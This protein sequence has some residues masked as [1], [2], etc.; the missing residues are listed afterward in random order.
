MAYTGF[1]TQVNGASDLSP[2]LRQFGFLN[3]G[4]TL[5]S[6]GLNSDGSNWRIA[7]GNAIAAGA[8][9]RGFSA[10]GQP[11]YNT[12]TGTRLPLTGMGGAANGWGTPPPPPR[13]GPGGPTITPVIP[14]PPGVIGAGGTGRTPT[15]PPAGAAPPPSS[16]PRPGVAPIGSPSAPPVVSSPAINQNTDT[17]NGQGNQ[18]QTPDYGRLF[19]PT[20]YDGNPVDST[21]Q[22]MAVQPPD[23]AGPGAPGQVDFNRLFNP[24]GYDGTTVGYDAADYL[25]GSMAGSPTISGVMPYSG[26]TGPNMAGGGLNPGT[27]PSGPNTMF[28]T[29][30]GTSSADPST[31]P[32]GFPTGA[33]TLGQSMYPWLTGY[34]GNFTAPMT[35]Y[36][37]QGLNAISQ[38]VGGG[39]NLGGAQSYLSNLLSGQYLDPS[40]NP[41]LAKYVSSLSGIHDYQDE[42]EKER[43]GS[44]MAAGGNALSGARAM[45]ESQYQ[46]ESNN[47]YQNMIASMLNSDYQMERGLQN[48]AVPLQMGISN[49]LMG[50]YGNLMNAG[51]L[52]RSIQQQENNAEYQDWLRQISGMQQAFQAPENSML[53]LL[54]SGYPGSQQ[55][56]YQGSAADSWLAALLGNGSG[57]SGL[58]NA[59]FG[60]GT[61]GG[62]SGGSSGGLLGSLANLLGIGGGSSS[63]GNTGGV[64]DPNNP[65]GDNYGGGVPTG[66]NYGP[67]PD[68]QGF[69][70][71]AGDP[72]LDPSNYATDPWGALD[73][74]YQ[75]Q[76]QQGNV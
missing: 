19:N 8:L 50:G 32:G 59:L 75:E 37:N 17:G 22:Q 74:W 57:S 49:E 48:Q 1:N 15:P 44:S 69:D 41:N 5:S 28:Q 25:S 10:T 20:G 12:P 43:I 64:S 29:N 33:Q 53:S 60:S 39:E 46:N 18:T 68:T 36:E 67:G 3:P 58:L 56:Q 2:F 55:Q 66:Q 6:Y 24:T 45:A 9:P 30:P 34:Q 38:F 31:M 11:I 40:T 7:E 27:T 4:Q 35:P 62:S 70:P 13:N 71:Y 16:A 63:G 47:Q 72:Y 23:A 21:S 54:H 26:A 76:Q 14:P 52:P 73:A 51:G 65:F 42:L 61:T